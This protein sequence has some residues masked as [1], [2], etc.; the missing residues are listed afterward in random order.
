MSLTFTQTNYTEATEG[1]LASNIWNA[2]KSVRNAIHIEVLAA[3]DVV[4]VANCCWAELDGWRGMAVAV[5]T[6]GLGYKQK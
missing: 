3:H 4:G 5:E 1:E 6:K 2:P